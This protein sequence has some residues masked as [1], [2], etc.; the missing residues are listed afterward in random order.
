MPRSLK[1]GVIRHKLL[2]KAYQVWY[3]KIN[4]IYERNQNNKRRNKLKV[5]I[6]HNITYYL[7]LS[8]G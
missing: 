4:N 5:T 6:V 7:V 8:H 3:N 2:V 1:T